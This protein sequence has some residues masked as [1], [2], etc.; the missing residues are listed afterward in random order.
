MFFIIKKQLIYII[1][2]SFINNLG[3]LIANKFIS[4]I[5][6]IFVL[7]WGTNYTVTYNEN[8]TKAIL[9]SWAR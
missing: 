9:F 4:K 3:F 6:K 2:I 1:S 7:E 5:S 8:K